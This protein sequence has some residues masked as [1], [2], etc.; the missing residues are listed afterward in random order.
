MNWDVFFTC[1]I[2]GAGDTTGKSDMVPVALMTGLGQVAFTS[3][4]GFGIA[5]LVVVGFFI[6]YVAE[7]LVSA[8][9]VRWNSSSA[10]P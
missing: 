2:T 8:S 10:S 1:A 3:V 5:M 9:H 7:P 4:I 6:R